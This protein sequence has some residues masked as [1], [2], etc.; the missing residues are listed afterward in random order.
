MLCACCRALLSP[1]NVLQAKNLLC[2]LTTE[3]DFEFNSCALLL[4]QRP[5]K[6]LPVHVC[7]VCA[8]NGRF[9]SS[10]KLVLPGHACP[11]LAGSTATVIESK[12]MS[13]P[14]V[15]RPEASPVPSMLRDIGVSA[16]GLG[17]GCAKCV[18]NLCRQRV[19]SVRSCASCLFKKLM[20]NNTLSVSLLQP[21][22]CHCAVVLISP[23]GCHCCRT[24]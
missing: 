10:G 9:H 3:S 21:P 24:V 23:R 18:Y 15:P 1:G 2:A 17:S 16:F 5:S 8:C 7:C 19:Y 20:F 12:T 14:R 6:V 4:Y 13:S 11:L 22:W